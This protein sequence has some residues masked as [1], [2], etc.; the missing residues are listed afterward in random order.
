MVFRCVFEGWAPGV[1]VAWGW[2]WWECGWVNLGGTVYW[3]GCRVVRLLGGA[4]RLLR[5]S[6]SGRWD[7]GVCRWCEL[8]EMSWRESSRLVKRFGKVL[9]RVRIRVSVVRVGF[10]WFSVGE[11]GVY[12]IWDTVGWFGGF[13]ERLQLRGVGAAIAWYKGVAGVLKGCY[14]GCDS[15]IRSISLER[16]SRASSSLVAKCSRVSCPFSWDSTRCWASSGT[17]FSR[18]DWRRVVLRLS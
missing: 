6:R 13:P 11:S 14:E 1:S 16:M 15:S 5:C 8:N 9:R 10:R 3:G 12:P 18:C 17:S 4:K 2:C 7:G